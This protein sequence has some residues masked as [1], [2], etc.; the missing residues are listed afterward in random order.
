MKT[1]IDRRARL[2][3][4]FFKKLIG[5]LREQARSLGYAIAV[6]G[7]VKRDIDLVAIPWTSDGG[8]ARQ[9]ADALFATTAIV[10]GF[11][12]VRSWSMKGAEHTLAGCPGD[13]P[14]GRLGWVFQLGGGVYIDLS[15]MPRVAEKGDQ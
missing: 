15:V 12:P 14:H 2:A 4:Q 10:M 13:K 7:S 8:D 9:L 6:H 3:P 11:V 1:E 5:P